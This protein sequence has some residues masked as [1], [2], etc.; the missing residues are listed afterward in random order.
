MGAFNF[1]PH[2]GLVN[3]SRVP[4]N[5]GTQSQERRARDPGF[6]RSQEHGYLMAM[7]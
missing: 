1:R 6:L 3:L 2:N 7:A 5:A 4:A